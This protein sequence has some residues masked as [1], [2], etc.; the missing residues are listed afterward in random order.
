MASKSELAEKKTSGVLHIYEKGDG[1]MSISFC[2][3]TFRTYP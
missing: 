2:G 3:T 1:K